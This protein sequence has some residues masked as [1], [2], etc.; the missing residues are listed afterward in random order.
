MRNE[1]KCYIKHRS[2]KYEK[3]RKKGSIS[4]FNFNTKNINYLIEIN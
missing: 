1:L 4:K 2:Q 3:T